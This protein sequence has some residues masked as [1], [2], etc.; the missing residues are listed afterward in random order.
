[1]TARPTPG[2]RPTRFRWFIVA[3]L[4]LITLINFFDRAAI[5]FAV[6]AIRKEFGFDA[7][8]MGWVLGA[9]GI[10]YLVSNPVCG[11]LIDRFGVRRVLTVTILAWALFMGMMALASTLA[12]MI[13]ARLCL[14]FGEGGGFPAITGMTRAW[15]APRERGVGLAIGAAAVPASSALGAPL[16][17]ALIEGHGWRAA[18]WALA[19]VTLLWALVW[20]WLYR[21]DPAR[22][23]FVGAA[24][25]VHIRGGGAAPSAAVGPVPWRAVLGNATVLATL[26]SAFV[27]G[28]DLFFFISWLPDTLKTEFGFSLGEIGTFSAVAWGVATLACVAGGALSDRIVAVGGRLR[29][30][31][32]LP[33]A[34]ARLG[35]GLA[36]GPIGL[37]LPPGVALP[38]IVVGLAFVMA[39]LP[40][41]FASNL[42]VVPGSAALAHGFYAA[43]VA[44]AG[45]LAPVSAGYIAHF[46]GSMAAVFVL[47]GVLGV[48]GAGVVLACHRPE[49][50]GALSP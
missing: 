50:D 6:P 31:R 38:L 5:A 3:T 29:T 18:Y 33:I 4:G 25:L 27:T 35:S 14:G 2:L 43:T 30:A 1:M 16:I 11:A 23:R 9:F 10:G 39:A 40:V 49:R 21:D 26:A 44:L 28:F 12:G 37:G 45:F 32:S 42:D 41:E 24:E 13:V 34:A 20:W 22:S 46:T 48:V 19:G 8:T 47:M 7:A 15:L 17:T 36:L